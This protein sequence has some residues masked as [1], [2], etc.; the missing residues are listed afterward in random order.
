MKSQQVS[1]VDVAHSVAVGDHERARVEPALQSL[2][3]AAGIGVVPG[4]DQ[5]HQP[6]VA[7]LAVRVDLASGQ[8]DRDVAVDGVVVE[9]VALDRVALIAQRDDELLEAVVRVVLHDVPQDRAA[10]DF[11]HRFGLHR[12]LFL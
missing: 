12:G 9:K 11:D 8:V 4:F 6:V 1:H 10:A 2:D 5:V 7:L 3:A